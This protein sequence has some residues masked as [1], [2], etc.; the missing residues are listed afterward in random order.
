MTYQLENTR[1]YNVSD[2]N[3]DNDMGRKY[4]SARQK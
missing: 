4:I 3:K 1:N 2:Y